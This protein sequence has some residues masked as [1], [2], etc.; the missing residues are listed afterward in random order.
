MISGAIGYG[1]VTL[2]GLIALVESIPPL[3]WFVTKTSMLVDILIFVGS[4]YATATLGYNLTAS[5]VVAGLGFSLVYAPYLRG[6]LLKKKPKS[7]AEK[8]NNNKADW[9]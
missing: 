7:R 1:L 3:K 2:V 4:I 9:S 6:T 8:W 5:L